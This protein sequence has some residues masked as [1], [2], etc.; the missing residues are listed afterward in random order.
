MTEIKSFWIEPVP[1]LSDIEQAFELAK[2]GVAVSIRWY[3]PYNGSHERVI[4]KDTTEKYTVEE[5]F[6]NCIPH[7]YGV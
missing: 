2:T 7:I 5:Y 4:L 3:V 6:K 1:K